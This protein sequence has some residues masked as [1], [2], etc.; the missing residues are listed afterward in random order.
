M[1]RRRKPPKNCNR[2]SHSLLSLHPFVY[3]TTIPRILLP[4]LVQSLL[5]SSIILLL[6]SFLGPSCPPCRRAH[7]SPTSQ[8]IV[9]TRKQLATVTRSD[10]ATAHGSN[11][12]N[13]VDETG[14]LQHLD[15]LLG[16]SA[17][18]RHTSY[19]FPLPW[20]ERLRRTQEMQ[21]GPD[22]GFTDCYGPRSAVLLL[23]RCSQLPEQLYKVHRN[24]RTTFTKV[25]TQHCRA[26]SATAY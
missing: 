6:F 7:V 20:N 21:H 10:T 4:S 18:S 11:S 16:Y 9:I 15:I 24:S 22:H 1:R 25:E 26:I 3:Y 2:P 19:T 5:C 8:T 12:A 17:S 23:Q 14:Q 13:V